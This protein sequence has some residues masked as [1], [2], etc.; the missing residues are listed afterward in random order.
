MPGVSLACDVQV[1]EGLC[2]LVCCR[3]RVSA[4]YGSLRGA[5]LDDHQPTCRLWL[6]AQALFFAVSC[7]LFLKSFGFQKFLQGW[8]L[9]LRLTRACALTS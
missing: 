9:C 3:P 4:R 6:S 5:C 2:E 8:I 1:L 7:P